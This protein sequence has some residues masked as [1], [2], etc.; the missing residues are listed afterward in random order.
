[1]MMRGKREVLLRRPKEGRFHDSR[2][3]GTSSATV[4]SMNAVT[5]ADKHLQTILML[6]FNHYDRQ[7]N[8]GRADCGDA[9]DEEQTNRG[10]TRLQVERSPFD[11]LA[12]S[13]ICSSIYLST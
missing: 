11:S 13:K 9:E 7:I 2:S 6:P 3:R 4:A 12:S 1:M 10:D 8:L 5:I